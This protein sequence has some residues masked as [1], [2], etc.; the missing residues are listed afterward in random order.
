METVEIQI[1]KFSELSDSAQTKARE[2]YLNNFDYPWFEEAVGSLKGFCE[3]FG[4][5][6]KNYEISPYCYSWV[7]TDAENRHFRGVTLKDA[8]KL[9]EKDLTGYCFD[10]S[11]T[12]EFYK[13]FKETGDALRAFNAAVDKWVKDVIADME[14]HESDECMR[15]TFNANDYYFDEDGRLFWK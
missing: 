5:E 12:G 14:Y 7:K 10:Y 9:E 1:Y 3:H 15:E 6:V 13:V 8:A 11:L 4:V 2:W